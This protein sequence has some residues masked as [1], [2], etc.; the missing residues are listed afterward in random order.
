MPGLPK[1][2]L[3]DTP[4]F[5]DTNRSDSDVLRELAKYLAKAYEYNILLTGLIYLHRIMDN[6]FTGASGRNLRTFKKLTGEENL[7]SVVLGTTFWKQPLSNDDLER[8][9]ELN[10]NPALGWAR[11]LDQGARAM[12]QD[13]GKSSGQDI[14]RHLIDRREDR[15]QPVVLKLQRQLVDEGRELADTSAGAELIGEMRKMHEQ[16]MARLRKEMLDAMAERDKAWQRQIAAQQ[17]EFQRLF[18]QN[19]NARYGLRQRVRD[20]W[21]DCVI[22]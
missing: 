13:R 15:G 11:M 19:E 7:G 5:D 1:F 17:A 21:D 8:E 22:M 6:R 18:S 10:T 14:I 20:W 2:F 4:G 16:Q 9:T 3:V 12:R